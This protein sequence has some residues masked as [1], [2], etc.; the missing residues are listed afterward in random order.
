MNYFV[1]LQAAPEFKVEIGSDSFN[2]R[3]PGLSNL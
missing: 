2:A 1:I 3:K